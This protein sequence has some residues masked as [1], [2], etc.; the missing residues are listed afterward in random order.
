VLVSLSNAFKFTQRVSAPIEV[1]EQV[2]GGE[3]TYCI[4]DNGAGFDWATLN[5]CK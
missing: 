1:T 5:A 3:A 4:R 2:H